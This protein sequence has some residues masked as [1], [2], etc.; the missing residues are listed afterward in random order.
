MTI[1]YL[2]ICMKTKKKKK[3]AKTD[4]LTLRAINDFL[5]SKVLGEITKTNNK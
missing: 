5:H 2:V 4:I 1:N 3:R